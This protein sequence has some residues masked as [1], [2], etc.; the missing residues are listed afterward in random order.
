MQA[1]PHPLWMHPHIQSC[2]HTGTNFFR[3]KCVCAH[4]HTHTRLRT[5][6]DSNVS[7]PAS[8]SST[9]AVVRKAPPQSHYPLCRSSKWGLQRHQVSSTS[10]PAGP[11]SHET[12]WWFPQPA[13]VGHAAAFQENLADPPALT[14]LRTPVQKETVV[15]NKAAAQ[16]TRQQLRLQGACCKVA[17]LTACNPSH[18]RLPSS[19]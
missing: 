16:S 4:T 12:G 14:A 5:H 17:S 8:A 7:Q 18:Q 9:S 10:P 15:G 2:T 3:R 19:A 1:K 6:T 11:L 13:H